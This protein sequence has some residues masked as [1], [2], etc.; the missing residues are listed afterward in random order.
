LSETISRGF[1][2]HIARGFVCFICAVGVSIF[3]FYG[4]SFA[5]HNSR[6]GRSVGRLVKEFFN[7]LNISITG[8]VVALS[9]SRG[10][11]VLERVQ[12]Q[13]PAHA[14]DLSYLRS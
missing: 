6:V 7:V 10:A 1:I 9:L 11:M 13:L 2:A 4:T 12:G 3:N 14:R 8:L 5:S